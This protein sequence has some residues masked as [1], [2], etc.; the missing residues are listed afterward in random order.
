VRHALYDEY[1]LAPATPSVAKEFEKM[2]QR[3]HSPPQQ[4]PSCQR[5]VPELVW[6]MSRAGYDAPICPDCAGV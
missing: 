5:F 3:L 6:A 1:A 2:G 4:C